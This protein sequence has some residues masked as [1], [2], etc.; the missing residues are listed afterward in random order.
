ML[1]VKYSLLRPLGVDSRACFFFNFFIWKEN[2]EKKTLKILL[3]KYFDFNQKQ[4][5]GVSSL[6]K[7]SGYLLLTTILWKKCFKTIKS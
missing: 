1:V 3:K 4:H 2:L 7:R 5:F 6:A